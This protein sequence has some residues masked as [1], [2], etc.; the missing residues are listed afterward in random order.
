MF[1]NRNATETTYEILKAKC[2]HAAALRIAR[3]F[4]RSF[5]QIKK[6]WPLVEKCDEYPEDEKLSCLMLL[7]LSEVGAHG[8]AKKGSVQTE[9]VE[10]IRRVVVGRQ[11]LL[12]LKHDMT[13][14]SQNELGFAQRFAERPSDALVTWNAVLSA[15]GNESLPAYRAA[16]TFKAY[17][18]WE[19]FK[20]FNGKW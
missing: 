8:R 18:L 6:L 11:Q 15:C 20:D 2:E 3:S 5:E 14:G 12:G 7:A 16:L 19:D 10:K 9:T 13:L 1:S 4:K 17:T